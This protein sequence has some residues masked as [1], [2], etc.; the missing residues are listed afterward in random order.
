MIYKVIIILTSCTT[1]TFLSKLQFFFLFSHHKLLMILHA[2]LYSRALCFR[3]I[4]HIIN[5]L[6]QV[7]FKK[8]IFA[9]LSAI[10]Y[11]FFY[12]SYSSHSIYTCDSQNVALRP[13]ASAAS[14]HQ[15]T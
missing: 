10:I 1:I 15:H 12:Y 3:Q 8:F 9:F 11:T 14:V 7:L 4:K 5:Y 2:E 13:A 6:K